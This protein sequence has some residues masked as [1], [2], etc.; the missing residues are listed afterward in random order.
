MTT[1]THRAHL[2]AI[3]G[4][5]VLLNACGNDVPGGPPGGELRRGSGGTTTVGVNGSGGSTAKG[6]EKGTIDPGMA[7]AGGTAGGVGGE[8]GGQRGGAVGSGGGSAGSPGSGG[9]PGNSGNAGAGG[10]VASGGS[11]GT[12]GSPGRGG[13][14]GIAG[15]GGAMAGGGAGGHGGAGGRNEPGVGDACGGLVANARSCAKG[16]FCEGSF[17]ELACVADVGGTCQPK[18]DVCSDLYA[19]VCGCDRKTYSSDCVRRAAG[20]SK[21]SDGA[22][23][24]DGGGGSKGGD[25]GRDGRQGGLGDA[26]GGFAGNARGCG[27]GLFC[28]GSYPEL[29]CASDA[30]GTCQEVPSGC[31]KD[32]R[33]VC[34]CD[35]KTYGNDCTRREAGVSKLADGECATADGC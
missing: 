17:P 28:E 25:G 10:K 23:A 7:G 32:Y 30:G 14:G 33:P 2:F 24:S 35:C 8:T 5:T 34:G 13:A 19:P 26:C 22:C 9:S 20:V 21:L 6:G 31:T 29:A 18:P 1:R 16:L 15:H 12:A 4:V 3:V 11:G 27:K